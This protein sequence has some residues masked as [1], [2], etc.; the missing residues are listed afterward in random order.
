MGIFR[1]LS[2][3]RLVLFILTCLFV[4]SI[5]T[6][7]FP[8]NFDILEHG[9]EWESVQLEPSTDIFL[10]EVFETSK[11]EKHSSEHSFLQRL[12]LYI[13]FEKSL[14]NSSNL[15]VLKFQVSYL[16]LDL[17]PPNSLT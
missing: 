17:P 10:A 14:F 7:S 8:F 9:P 5:G 6:V 13:F 2:G 1:S 15:V 11:E 4:C 16:H 12:F 3:N